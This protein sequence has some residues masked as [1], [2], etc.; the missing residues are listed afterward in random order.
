MKVTKVDPKEKDDK[1]VDNDVNETSDDIMNSEDEFSILDE[2]NSEED[3]EQGQQ[4]LTI[5]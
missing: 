2:S 5:Q 1:K 3:K 4:G